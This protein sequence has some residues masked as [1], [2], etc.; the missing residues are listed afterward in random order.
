LVIPAQQLLKPLRFYVFILHSGWI[1]RGAIVSDEFVSNVHW[2]VKSVT[3]GLISRRLQTPEIADVLERLAEQN[4]EASA[5]RPPRPKALP[6]CSMLPDAVGAA[7]P[8]ASDVAAAIAAVE[9]D[10]HWKQNPNYSDEA[11][12]ARGYMDGYA[13]AEI[14][15]PSGFFPGDDFLLGLLLLG[16]GQ[17]YR[18]HYHA[19]PELYWMLTGP[20]NWKRGAGGWEQVEAGLTRWHKPFVVH[21]TATASAPLLCLWVWTRNTAEPARLVEPVRSLA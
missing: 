10:L 12:G 18:E 15:G 1:D 16:P 8:V 19:A 5:F 11:M 14:I 17:L 4:L 3:R 20:S 2:L 9:D 7:L 6:V 21:A 13:Y